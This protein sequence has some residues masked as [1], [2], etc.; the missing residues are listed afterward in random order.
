[1][2]FNTRAM[3]NGTNE[4]WKH[5][6]P[7]QIHRAANPVFPPCAYFSVWRSLTTHCQSDGISSSLPGCWGSC[8]LETFRATLRSCSPF[9]SCH[10]SHVQGFQNTEAERAESA[11]AVPANAFVKRLLPCPKQNMAWAMCWFLSEPREILLPGASDRRKMQ[12]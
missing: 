3:G 8:R 10:P 7:T 1:M 5:E 4:M 12:M 6:S 11:A 9:S 2:L